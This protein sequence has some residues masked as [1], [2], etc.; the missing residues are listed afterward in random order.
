MAAYIHPT[1]TVEDAVQLADDV[2]IG[3]HCTLVGPITIGAGSAL[4]G[5]TF[6]TGPLTIGL[7]NRI[8]PFVCLGFEPQDYKY[9]SEAKCAGIRIGDGNLIR[10]HVTVHRSTSADCPTTIGDECM[11]MVGAHVGHDCTVGNR[12]VM[13]NNAV[14]AGHVIVEDQVTISGASGIAQNVRLGRLS[15]V[16][17]AI[18]IVQHLPPFMFARKMNRVSGLNL[19][20]LRRSGMTHEEIDHLRAAFRIIYEERNSRSMV[21]EKLCQL[22]DISPAVRELHDYFQIIKGAIC[23]RDKPGSDV[24]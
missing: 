12:C 18:G 9:D 15:F 7:N 4:A 19:I 5:H 17:G 23:K 22:S 2:V 20:G 8:Y 24:K 1:S 16:G 11:L 13:V 14:L 6:L 10:E 3:P 21:M